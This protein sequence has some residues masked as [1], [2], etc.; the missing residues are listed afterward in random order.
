MKNLQ[1]N[2]KQR[3]LFKRQKSQAFRMDSTGSSS[4][5]PFDGSDEYRKTFVPDTDDLELLKY[6]DLNDTTDRR[7]LIGVISRNYDENLKASDS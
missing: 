5:S 2:P 6:V 7:L 3:M 4:Q 1:L